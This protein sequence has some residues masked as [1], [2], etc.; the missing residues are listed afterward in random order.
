MAFGVGLER[1]DFDLDNL[2]RRRETALATPLE[3]GSLLSPFS[4]SLLLD[5]LTPGEQSN[6]SPSPAPYRPANLE[7]V[8]LFKTRSG[9]RSLSIRLIQPLSVEVRGWAQVYVADVEDK[10][11]VVA[12]IVLKLLVEAFFWDPDWVMPWIPAEESMSA[13]LQAYA[14]P[15]PVQGQDVP[16]CYGA[17][18]FTM[19]WGET[20]PGILLEDLTTTT[21][22]SWRFMQ[23]RRDELTVQSIDSFMCAAHVLLHRLQQLGVADFAI[24]A[25]DLLLVNP[26]SLQH[27]CF[28]LVDF[29]L[30][31]NAQQYRAK[32]DRYIQENNCIWRPWQSHADYKLQGELQDACGEVVEEWVAFER[33]Q[34]RGYF[35]D[36]GWYDAHGDEDE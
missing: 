4:P 16:H 14:T 33:K 32:H 30:A 29:G 31:V 34:R 12:R 11:R 3:V 21:T 17:Y 7:L 5:A 28:I 36:P 27:P 15:R 19:P 22:S 23:D 2:R 1:P 8:N 18:Q 9:W 24:N 10:G 25:L 13:E 20:V 6:A 35:A 26:P